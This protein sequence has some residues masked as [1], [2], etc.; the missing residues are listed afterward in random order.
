MREC[1]PWQVMPTSRPLWLQQCLRSRWS[2]CAASSAGNAPA[3]TTVPI[4][5]D[6]LVAAN[7]LAATDVDDL[8]P[9]DDERIPR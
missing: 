6:A 5:A 8:G 2:R 7:D 1:W 4:A 9:L 3:A